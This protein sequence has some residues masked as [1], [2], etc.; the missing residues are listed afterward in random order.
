MSSSGELVGRELLLA[1]ALP[2]GHHRIVLG[3]QA[4][5]LIEANALVMLSALGAFL[6]ILVDRGCLAHTKR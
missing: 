1:N 5:N 4:S 3:H 2:E 6:V